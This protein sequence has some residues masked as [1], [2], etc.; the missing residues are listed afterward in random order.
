MK[1]FF[2]TLSAVLIMTCATFT[3]AASFT[4]PQLDK[5]FLEAEQSP[6]TAATLNLNAATLTEKFNGI[7]TPILKEAMGTDDISAMAHLF[8]IKDAK[9]FSKAN[10][11]TFANIFG[12]YR[13][14]LVGLSESN[15][16]NFKNLHM[17]YTTPESNDDSIF[18]IWLMTAFVKSIAPD[19][20]VQ[21]LMNELTAEN[22][23]GTVVKGGIKFSVAE[24]GNL[25][26]LTAMP[27]Q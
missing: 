27:A 8:L 14:A 10:G 17:Y 2:V 1:K 3:E 4:Q 20:N 12:D 16:G 26:V 6:T 9:I 21:A 22:S 15:G 24:D 23:S 7:V 18:T 13:V 25:N 11:D 19:V 5:I